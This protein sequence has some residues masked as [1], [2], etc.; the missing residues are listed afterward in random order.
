MEVIVGNRTYDTN[1]LR[2]VCISLGHSDYDPRQQK[3]TGLFSKLDVYDAGDVYLLVFNVTHQRSEDEDDVIKS[4]GVI[5]LSTELGELIASHITSHGRAP[6]EPRQTLA[7]VVHDI[8]GVLTSL[9]NRVAADPSLTDL[10]H[11]LNEMKLCLGVGA[12]RGSLALAGRALESVLKAILQRSGQKCDNTSMV[13]ALLTQMEKAGIYF[14]PGTKNVWNI[15]NQQRIVGV[16]VKEAAPIPSR[17]QAI[18]VAYAVVDMLK[19]RLSE[20]P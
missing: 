20:E 12:F 3:P 10:V 13:G 11:D 8:D 6:A 19:R 9:R 16:H 7:F 18:M 2:R 5:P 17:E 14:D 15:I 4:E 1:S